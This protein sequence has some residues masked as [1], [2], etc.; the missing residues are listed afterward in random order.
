MEAV[1]E[2]GF[3]VDKEYGEDVPKTLIFLAVEEAVGEDAFV[4]VLMS[5]GA[6]PDQRNPV[7]ETIPFQ[8]KISSGNVLYFIYKV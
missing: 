5:A 7:L 8:G 1:A 2:P 3:D 6:R 4:S